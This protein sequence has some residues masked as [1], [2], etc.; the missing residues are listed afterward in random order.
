M[1]RIVDDAPIGVEPRTAQ[2]VADDKAERDAQ[3]WWAM[4][5]SVVADLEQSGRCDS[6]QAV[7]QEVERRLKEKR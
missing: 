3:E 4:H 2:D 7:M 5:D 1:S 6:P